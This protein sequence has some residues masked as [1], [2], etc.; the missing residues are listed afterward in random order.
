MGRSGGVSKGEFK[1]RTP[2]QSE[3]PSWGGTSS[4]LAAYKHGLSKSV[5]VGVTGWMHLDLEV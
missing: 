4:R 5:R 1:S 3:V 2:V